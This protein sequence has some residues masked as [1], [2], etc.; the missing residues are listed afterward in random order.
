[1][2][3]RFLVKFRDGKRIRIDDVISFEARQ[4]SEIQ[5]IA[6]NH[7]KE[8][9]KSEPEGKDLSYLTKQQKQTVINFK[10]R[11]VAGKTSEELR[12]QKIVSVTLHFTE[13]TLEREGSNQLPIIIGLIDKIVAVDSVL[14]AQFKGYS[15]LSYTTAIQNDPDHYKLPITFKLYR[16]RRQVRMITI[17]FRG[18]PPKNLTQN[19]IQDS[20]M[21]ERM[22]EFKRKLLE[23]SRKNNQ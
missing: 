5:N 1:M 23:Q 3:K 8:E 12:K 19:I 21:N 6:S 7:T 20:A 10:N 15:T 2:A 16:D 13:R 9:L 11:L 17:A 18:A 22:V 14:K 4:I